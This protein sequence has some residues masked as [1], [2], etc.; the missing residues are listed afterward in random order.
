MMNQKM[1][2]TL[3][4]IPLRTWNR[5]RMNDCR[6]SLESPSSVK[7]PDITA[8]EGCHYT[9]SGPLPE[10]FADIGTGMG[11]DAEKVFAGALRRARLFKAE[12][13]AA[14]GS[15]MLKYDFTPEEA[16]ADVVALE[17]GENAEMQMIMDFTSSGKGGGYGA[18]QTRIRAGRHSL[19]RLIQVHRISSDIA[20]LNDVGAVCDEGARV[21]VIHVILSGAHNLIGCRIDLEGRESSMQADIG[22]LVEDDH[23][24]DMNYAV[25][26]I[27]RRTESGISSLG[28]LRDEGFKL[29][30]GTIDFRKGAAGSVGSEKEDVLLM[31]DTVINQTIP[32]I[33]CA[34]EDVEGNHGATIGQLD[35]ETMF[36]MQS[37]GIPEKEIYALME[38][39]RLSSVITRIPDEE[40]RYELLHMIGTE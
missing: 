9:E 3:N 1:D 11:P 12:S 24:L 38:R 2:V 33:L 18:V 37:R 8:P 39:S 30:R 23:H 22:Y 26:H 32:V 13:G 6:M 20:M 34:E 17:T 40:F 5:L 35:E 36:Y 31:D 28:I 15:I 19:V 25:N 7:K 4:R 29:F 27:G 16:A 14:S 21:E 10:N